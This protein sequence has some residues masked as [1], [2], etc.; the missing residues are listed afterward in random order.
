MRACAPLFARE[1]SETHHVGA[2]TVREIALPFSL[3][4]TFMPL[5]V[6]LERVPLAMGRAR[7][8]LFVGIIGS[9][10]LQTPL[11]FV[12]TR[13]LKFKTPLYRLYTGVAIGYFG[14]CLLLL[15]FIFFADW[16]KYAADAVKRSNDEENDDIPTAL[17]GE[18]DAEQEHLLQKDD[19]DVDSGVDGAEKKRE[20][21]IQ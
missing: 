19:D 10:V 1:P 18:V 8:V 20:H 11:A 13:Y 15:A 5:S 16:S 3:V 17:K 4:C 7:L 12:F 9:W 14:V 2:P 6:A 21:S